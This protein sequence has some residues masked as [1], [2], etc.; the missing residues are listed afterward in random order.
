[1][2]DTTSLIFLSTFF[3]E[4][5]CI[6]KTK[7]LNSTWVT[8][9]HSALIIMCYFLYMTCREHLLYPSQ[10]GRG[11][12]RSLTYI[13]IY[14]WRLILWHILCCHVASSSHWWVHMAWWRGHHGWDR[15]ETRQRRMWGTVDNC[16]ATRMKL[17]WLW[18][19]D[20]SSNTIVL[21][22]LQNE[23]RVTSVFWRK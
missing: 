10:Q 14:L 17:W 13:G 19:H 15:N 7:L 12:W 1:M 21:N 11:V 18:N 6:M 23:H 16:V 8:E 22:N 3:L 5:C 4:T 2:E 9:N 20:D